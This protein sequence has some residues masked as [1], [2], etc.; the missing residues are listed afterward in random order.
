MVMEKLVEWWLARE[1]EVLGEKLPQCRFVHHKSHMLCPGANPDR[2]G[3]KP[4]SNRFSYGTARDLYLGLPL[5]AALSHHM[6]TVKCMSDSRRGFGLDIGFILHFFFQWLLQPLQ[7]PGR[8]FSSVIIFYTDDRTHWTN[9][10]LVVRPLPMH[11]T[12]QTQHKRIHRHPCLWDSNSR[13][14]RSSEQRQFMP[15]TSRPLWS[16]I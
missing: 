4:V 6:Y 11:R 13:S 10:K 5:G 3:G 9:D 7:G 1:T 8:Y 2:W 12:T 16:A 15:Y 14:Q